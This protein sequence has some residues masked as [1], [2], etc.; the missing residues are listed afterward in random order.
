MAS[1]GVNVLRYS[2]L[3]GGLFYGAWHQATLNTQA[4]DAE[5]DREYKHKESLIQQAKAEWLRKNP[6]PPKPTGLVT[7]PEDPRFDLEAFLV[8]KAAE[9]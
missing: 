2:A 9:K 5:K 8:A 1:Q 4:K 6:P 7:D 3:L